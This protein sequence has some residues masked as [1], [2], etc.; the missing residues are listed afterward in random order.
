MAQN[1]TARPQS[2]ENPHKTQATNPPQAK[3]KE[4]RIQAAK[5]ELVDALPDLRAI[6]TPIRSRWWMRSNKSSP[7]E[8]MS[9]QRSNQYITRTH[10][11]TDDHYD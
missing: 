6:A 4:A 2:Q 11:R 5:C 8:L 7:W 9:G 3:V 10:L 1:S